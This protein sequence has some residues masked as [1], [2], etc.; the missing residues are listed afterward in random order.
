MRATDSSLSLCSPD[1][2]GGALLPLGHERSGRREDV[3]HFLRLEFPQELPEQV[4]ACRPRED[5]RVGA[6]PSDIMEKLVHGF[7]PA[8]AG[9]DLG[10]DGEM[11]IHRAFDINSENAS[12][13]KGLVL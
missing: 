9:V 3:L 8:D 13:I 1:S 4:I 12:V 6:Q 2:H 7:V 11:T 10:R 5:E